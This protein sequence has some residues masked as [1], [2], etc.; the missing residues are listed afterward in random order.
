M[1]QPLPSCLTIK[2]SPIHGLGLFANQQI[3][4]GH[5]LGIAHIE[6]VEWMSF[7]QNH[8]RTPL[9]GFYN[10]SPNPNCQ[11]VSNGNTKRLVTTQEIEIDQEITCTYTLYRLWI[12]V[13][14]LEVLGF[15]KYQGCELISGTPKPFRPC[16]LGL[17]PIILP[18]GRIITTY[19][20]THR[21]EYAWNPCYHWLFAYCLCHCLW[22]WLCLMVGSAN[23]IQYKANW[24]HSA[25][26]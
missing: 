6:M 2:P 8:C 26:I 21:S 9:G 22:L 4:A 3:P 11:L 18:T 14:L 16:H 24:Q 20:T 17:P 25:T 12:W 23:P 19:I 1:Y 15:W 13:G 7:P 5:D 10:H